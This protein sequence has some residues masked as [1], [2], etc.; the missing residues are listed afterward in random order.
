MNQDNRTLLA[1]FQDIYTSAFD[2]KKQLRKWL[3]ISIVLISA[4]Y[5]IYAFTN[6][7]FIWFLGKEIRV[8]VVV[9]ILVLFFKLFHALFGKWYIH[10]TRERLSVLYVKNKLPRKI[11]V[12]GYTR[13]GKDSSINAIKKHL[14]DDLIEKIKDDLYYIEMICY[15][16]NFD[17]LDKYLNE[18]HSSFMINSKN[19]F[20]K[21]FI[22]MMEKN[23][24]F[25][26][27]YYSKNFDTQ[28]HLQE[29][30]F[31]T[32]N[33][34]D[35][36]VDPIKYKYNDNIK[37]KHYLTLLIK[38]CMLYIRIHYLDNFIIS[39]QPTMETNEKPAKVF[40]T[41]FTN[42][43]KENAS[44]PWPIDGNIIVIETE[45]DGLYPN[46]GMGKNDK[47]MKTGFRNFKAFI[48]HL[49][50]EN[51]VYINLG[52]NAS[53]TEKSIRELDHVFLRVIEQ[54]KVFGGE[55][56][57]YLINK[58]LSWIEFWLKKSPR[59]KAREKQ[60]R[61]RSRMV[62][63]I[64]RLKNSGYIY[65]DIKISRSEISG[66]APEM[67]VKKI[68]KYD[69]AINENYT[70]K[71]CF[72]LIDNY[73]GYNTHYIESVAESKAAKTTEQ[74]Q[75]VM[76]WDPDLILK[77][78][79]IEYMGY[80]VLDNIVGIDRYK[81]EKQQKQKEIKQKAKEKTDEV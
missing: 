16:Y 1:K 39:N 18:N 33:P 47:P 79:H 66:L 77:R 8:G 10:A 6:F 14:R 69:K 30:Y 9:F 19:K 60:Y 28:S 21:V 71:L 76:S 5:L 53:R 11:K 41:R 36:D 58:L 55:K 22:D 59:K 32:K 56:R 44:W 68:L 67:T 31:I 48:A 43:Q 3:I 62:E 25:I 78:K 20:F 54:T 63:K 17:L 50:G 65:V 51:T 7:D 57:I 80:K 40:S 45:A 70:V 64:T 52:Q 26:K 15:P 73:F 61:R 49:L 27:K 29:L 4:Y 75:D 34:F 38:Y 2:N 46:V 72:R 12:E 42:I 37:P 35:K 13:S 74:F 23:N 24:C 81:L